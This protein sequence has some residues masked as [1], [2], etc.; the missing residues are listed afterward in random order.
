MTTA[1]SGA[2]PFQGL[3]EEACATLC[4]Y[5]DAEGLTLEAA[6]LLPAFDRAIRATI[7]VVAGGAPDDLPPDFALAYLTGRI[8]REQTIAIQTARNQARAAITRAEEHWRAAIEAERG[9]AARAAS[10]SSTPTPET[11]RLA[12]SG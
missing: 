5:L 3:A 9:R 12:Q 1:S 6:A 2:D 10:A 4:E 11:S 7:A 8:A